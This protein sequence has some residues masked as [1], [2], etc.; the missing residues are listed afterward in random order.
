MKVTDISDRTGCLTRDFVGHMARAADGRALE[1][2]V[3]TKNTRQSYYNMAGRHQDDCRDDVN[4]N[5]TRQT[6]MDINRCSILGT[7]SEQV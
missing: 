7:T 1:T 2:V 3:R 6:T 5:S 4:D